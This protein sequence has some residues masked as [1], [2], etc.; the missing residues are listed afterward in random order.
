MAQV[1]RFAI[2]LDYSGGAVPDLH[3]IPCFVGSEMRLPTTNARR[4]PAM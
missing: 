3:R 2:L 4:T 1:E